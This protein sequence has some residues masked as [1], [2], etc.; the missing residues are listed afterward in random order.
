MPARITRRDFLKLSG[1]GLMS[2]LLS[3]IHIDSSFA[4]GAMDGLQGRVIAD[5][6]KVYAEPVNTSRFVNSFF[7]DQV[8]PIT[9]TAL[10]VDEKARNRIWYKMGAGYAHSSQVQ[11]VRTLLNKPEANLR[12][13]GNLVEVSVPYTDAYKEPRFD[14]ALVVYR[15]YYETTYW[16]DQVVQDASGNVWYRFY[17]DKRKINYY[18]PAV[19]LR[20]ITDGEIAPISPN[21]DSN[22]KLLTVNVT[23]EIVTAYEDN[24]PVFMSR[25][26]SG[27]RSYSIF[28]TTPLGWHITN[29]KRLTRH[30]A[31]GDPASAEGFDL[32]GI[33]WVSY[34]T[35]SGVSFHGT[36]WHNDFGTP[37]SHGCVNLTPQAAKWVLR[38]S[39]PTVPPGQQYVLKDYGTSVNVIE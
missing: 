11:P 29:H 36:Y 30:M 20:I 18:A 16:V 13:G 24:K 33:P 10:G 14:P 21:M 3:G 25:C 19:H 38:W 17:D 7:K 22:K 34:F 6:I 9:E 23:D 39:A 15:L 35:R 4:Q 12:P 27:R 2:A 37:R 8:I 32:P 31:A 26:S 5:S 1:A 28:R